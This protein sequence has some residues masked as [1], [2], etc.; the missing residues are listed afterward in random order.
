MVFQVVIRPPAIENPA[1]LSGWFG[2]PIR[3]RFYVGLDGVY[4]CGT[5][6]SDLSAADPR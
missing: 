2:K 6:Q 1:Y 3:T 5:P 4:Q